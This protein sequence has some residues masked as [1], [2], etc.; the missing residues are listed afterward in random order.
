MTDNNDNTFFLNRPPEKGV[1]LSQGLMI[2]ENY[3]VVSLIGSGGMGA[4]YRVKQVFF[5]KEFALKILDFQ[6]Q[7][8]VSVR[9]FQQEARTASQLQHSNLVEVHDF[10]M[11][12]ES[13]PYLVMDLVEGKTLSEILKKEGALSIDYVV[14][15]AIQ[16]SLGLIYAH[17]KGVVHRDIKPGNIML[18]HPDRLV[19][20]G[21][22][23][24]VDF[25][26]A[27][28]MQSEAG[29]IQELTKTG[30]IFGSPVYMSPEQCRGSA[31]DKRSDIYSL[32]CVIFECLTGSP[33]FL[34]EN[35]MSTML[36]RLSEAP[37]SLKEGSL[38]REFPQGLENIVR[39]MLAIEPDDRYQDLHEVISDFAALQ[40]AQSVALTNIDTTNLATANFSMANHSASNMSITNSGD[41]KKSTAKS[42][43]ISNRAWLAAAV[44]MVSCLGTAAFDTYFVLPDL[45][46]A[47]SK[48][49]IQITKEILDDV[50]EVEQAQNDV[51]IKK[52]DKTF[53][54]D[55]M[56]SYPHV[57]YRTSPAGAKEEFLVFPSD[58]GK[59]TFGNGAKRTAEGEFPL[60]PN[61]RITL[62][63]SRA[64][65]VDAD[66]LKN[67]THLKFRRIDFGGYLMVKEQQIAILEKIEH[68]EQVGLE[69]CNIK[70]LKPLYN[71][72]TLARIEVGATFV[73]TEE[74]LKLRNLGIL[75]NLT[76][77]PVSDP[78]IV[79]NALA[80]TN[81]INNLNYKGARLREL[82]G[83]GLEPRDIEALAK[84]TNLGILSI[85]TC[86][87][88]DDN[89]L[90]KLLALKNLHRI[91]IK[92]CAIT[93][94]SIPT[95]S[96]FKWLTQLQLTTEGWSKEEVQQLRA[97]Y[98]FVEDET[99]TKLEDKRTSDVE[100]SAGLLKY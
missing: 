70:S 84:L 2:N 60:E 73:P 74:I 81:K 44:A 40:E 41:P 22:V 14:A 23:K 43:S 8:D 11:F 25:G 57:E 31:V 83:K 28:L 91:K 35:A 79:F 37:V 99:R 71:S 97:K 6:N 67:I 90:R 45:I 39:K 87:K 1:A 86:P 9:R 78:S 50:N 36:K 26:I 54:K 34:G 96:K 62:K 20:E 49:R 55:S 61:A 4:V 5:G 47:E 21:T 15:L 93:P 48:A 16:L 82:E 32:G 13:Q 88:F 18:L 10:G 80:K 72:K 33:P 69:N 12:G 42:F 98:D 77:G 27:K 19:I 56:G 68:L 94:N 3:E 66:T 7:S 59:I 46:A 63:L 92:D 75:E 85:E 89:S 100:G 53:G 29:E 76:F 95:F 58:C 17:E 38:G 64:A 30:E 65:S 24:I 52:L 51:A